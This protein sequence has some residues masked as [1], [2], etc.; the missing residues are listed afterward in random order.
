MCKEMWKDLKGYHGHYKI[1]NLGGLHNLV[2]GTITYGCID[3]STGYERFTLYKDGK[4]SETP[5]V[6][7]L[8]A[9]HFLPNPYN[10]SEVNHIDEDKTNNCVSNLEWCDR[11]YNCNYGTRNKRSGQSR[12]NH[13][14]KSKS[15]IGI[16][17]TNGLIMEFPSMAEAERQTNIAHQSISACCRG[18]LETA[19]GYKWIFKNV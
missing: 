7:R 14:K 11:E 13:P 6:H 16:S 5:Y 9:M 15:I 10:H 2:K 17:K 12:V 19:G 8:V 4:I 18:K 3:K 1:S